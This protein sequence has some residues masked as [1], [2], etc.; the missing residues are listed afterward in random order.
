MVKTRQVPPVCFALTTREML[1]LT[2]G[3]R[4]EEYRDYDPGEWPEC[5]ICDDTILALP[6]LCMVLPTQAALVYLHR[7]C[8]KIVAESL[9]ALETQLQ[10]AKGG[11]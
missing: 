2:F 6:L 7:D 10:S 11:R 8:G 4:G 3:S 1:D 9:Q 5:S